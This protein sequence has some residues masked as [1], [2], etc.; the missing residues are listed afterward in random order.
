[1]THAVRGFGYLRVKR[2]IGRLG[3]ALLCVSSASVV[4]AT[5]QDSAYFAFDT[6]VRIEAGVLKRGQ[7][8]VR[9]YQSA[10]EIVDP[11]PPA[12][13][14]IAALALAGNDILYTPDIAFVLN[15]VLV[16]PRDVVRHGAGGSSVH[17]RGSDLGLPANVGIDALAVAGSD[18][19]FSLDTATRING[20][21]VGPADVLRWNSATVSILHSAQAL[22]LP[23]GINL[24]ALER[25]ANGN[26]LVGVD[27]AGNVGGIA[28]MAGEIVEYAPAANHWSMARDQSQ[29][30]AACNPCKL[31]AFA[32]A[33]N[34]D[35]L[36][37]SGMERNEN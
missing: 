27:V 21:K 32:A 19:L 36:F 11:G 14:R 16:T 18:I 2:V 5:W 6:A 23:S 35:V 29:F 1:M 17:L 33:G 13:V 22:G 31:A 8:L 20:T 3:A 34:P 24:V 30:G 28:F 26:L 25:F 15:G 37:R 9:R 7:V 4:A 12:N 10:P